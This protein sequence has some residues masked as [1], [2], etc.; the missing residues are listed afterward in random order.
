MAPRMPLR[1][2]SS[3]N[4]Q[5]YYFF[6]NRLEYSQFYARVSIFTRLMLGYA[7]SRERVIAALCAAMRALATSRGMPVAMLEMG[8]QPA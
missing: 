8:M 6:A 1:T 2:H 7:A 3:R 5:R 4:R